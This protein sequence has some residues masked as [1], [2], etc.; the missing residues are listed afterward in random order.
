M[1]NVQF[2]TTETWL[3]DEDYSLHALVGYHTAKR[4]IVNRIGGG[5]YIYIQ[6]HLTYWVRPDISLFNQVLE[7]LFIEVDGKQMDNTK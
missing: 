1:L 6:D 3:Q 4:R 2:T 7:S 5:V